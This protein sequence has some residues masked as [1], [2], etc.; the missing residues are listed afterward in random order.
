MDL[1][2]RIRSVLDEVELLGGN[3]VT[4]WLTPNDYGVLEDFC[5]APNSAQGFR[6]TIRFMGYP[7]DITHLSHSYMY[8][9]GRGGYPGYKPI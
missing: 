3:S 9:Y 1:R 5:F 2:D 4:I 8:F 6:H 7:V